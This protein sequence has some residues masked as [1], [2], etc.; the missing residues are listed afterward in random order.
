LRE[1]GAQDDPA[2]ADE[3][4]VGGSYASLP[5]GVVDERGGGGGRAAFAPRQAPAEPEDLAERPPARPPIHPSAWKA[6][7]PNFFLRRI[8]EVHPERPKL[9]HTGDAP[10]PPRP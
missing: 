9:A 4:E 6:N 1:P 8:Q 7:S 3:A 10:P 2:S 5:L